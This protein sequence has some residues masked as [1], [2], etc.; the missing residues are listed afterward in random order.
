MNTG[1]LSRFV[2]PAA[3][4]SACAVGFVIGGLKPADTSADP[5]APA[6]QASD[7]ASRN[8]TRHEEFLETEVSRLAAVVYETVAANQAM[9]I[10]LASLKEQLELVDRRSDAAEPDVV[11]TTTSQP[12]D[13]DVDRQ[14][15]AML[16]YLDLQLE[17]TSSS[18]LDQVAAD[19][20][21][22]RLE[23]SGDARHISTTCTE[24]LCRLEIQLRTDD[25]LATM[26]HELSGNLS[27][28]HDFYTYSD[29]ADPLKVVA[30]LSRPGQDLNEIM[31]R[32]P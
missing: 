25:S 20:I 10:E 31:Q 7:D 1:P 28:E 5:N 21:S 23:V 9:A 3:L 24:A 27:W 14:V 15:S 2:L 26:V 30:Y 4:L 19:E 18:W 8:R 32:L 17:S 12:A 29:P 11:A 6:L 13:V 16:N 22:R